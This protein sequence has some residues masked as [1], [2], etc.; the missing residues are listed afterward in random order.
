MERDQGDESASRV[1]KPTISGNGKFVTFAT[2]ATNMS[3]SPTNKQQHIY[4]AEVDTGRLIRA[5]KN[6]EGVPGNG[7]SPISQGERIP[8]SHDG[9]WI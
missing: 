5:S 9:Y 8:I 7:N 2:T 6:A 4:V 3:G 1:V